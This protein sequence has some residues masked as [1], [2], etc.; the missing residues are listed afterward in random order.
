MD[1]TENGTVS[2]YEFFPS[3]CKQMAYQ[4]QERDGRN[5]E[6]DRTTED[7]NDIYFEDRDQENID[8]DVTDDVKTIEVNN[9][10]IYSQD[11]DY[12]TIEVSVTDDAEIRSSYNDDIYSEDC[13]QENIEEDVTDD[14]KTTEVNDISTYSQDSDHKNI[15][16]CVTDDA[17][18]SGGNNDDIYSEDREHENVKQS[19][20]DTVEAT[21]GYN[22]DRYSQNSDCEDIERNGTDTVKTIGGYNADLFSQDIDHKNTER[23]VTD[24]VKIKEG[25]NDDIYSQSINHG[26]TESCGIVHVNECQNS[27]HLNEDCS[28]E[29]G[30]SKELETEKYG[31][32]E[33][34][35]KKDI[36]ENEV[37][38]GKLNEVEDVTD[39]NS[40]IKGG[41]RDSLSV[42]DDLDRFQNHGA[43]LIYDLFYN[44]QYRMSNKPVY[45]VDAIPP[46]E[47][48]A[49]ERQDP[50]IHEPTWHSTPYY[51][52]RETYFTR[53]PE[54]GNLAGEKSFLYPI[55]DQYTPPQSF[56]LVDR[57]ST[58]SS[59]PPM[60]A[61]CA[62]ESQYFAAD[63]DASWS[64]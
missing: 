21:E 28:G 31:R 9:V 64:Y 13:E 16:V 12:K 29:C 55:V 62:D 2:D 50:T 10:S 24:D 36:Y 7:N 26:R 11:S 53:M 35:D 52:S 46:T 48:P 56:V 43:Y 58:S 15:E 54:Q 61:R 32:H 23:G 19:S 17:K 22:D 30:F 47:R 8:E 49:F 34:A 27:D 38:L 4:S 45:D 51:P 63:E 44:P 37:Q 14:G 33:E 18:I 39:T 5:E 60:S 41:E 20:T 57:P 1:S 42:N 25:D 6:E 3:Q 59:Y 40:L